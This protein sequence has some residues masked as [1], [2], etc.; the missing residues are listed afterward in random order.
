MTETEREELEREFGEF[1]TISELQYSD[2]HYNV[3][4]L[5]FCNA[6]LACTLHI[7]M[8]I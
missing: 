6:L 2:P 7:C 3:C 5:F 1:A 4:A 8:L